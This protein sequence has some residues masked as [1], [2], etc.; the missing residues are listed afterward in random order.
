MFDKADDWL[1]RVQNLYGKALTWQVFQEEFYREYLTENYWKEK[2]AAFIN[3][4]QG[5]MAVREYA[6]KFEDL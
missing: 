5:S 1:T 2:V 4:V 3:L 6:D